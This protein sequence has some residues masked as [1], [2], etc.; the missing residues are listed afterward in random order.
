MTKL[1]KLGM[2]TAGSYNGTDKPG[3]NA[4]AKLSQG[5]PDIASHLHKLP[6]RG[7]SLARSRVDASRMFRL[8]T[9]EQPVMSLT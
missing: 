3:W 4:L 9:S 6:P 2:G 7:D 1:R 5:N 8:A